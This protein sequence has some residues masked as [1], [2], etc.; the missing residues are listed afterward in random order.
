MDTDLFL[1]TFCA[2]KSQALP[3]IPIIVA[4]SGYRVGA[5][6]NTSQVL[7]HG[8]QVGAAQ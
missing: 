4:T 8:L 7:G 5:T 3:P 2:V 1:S 6:D